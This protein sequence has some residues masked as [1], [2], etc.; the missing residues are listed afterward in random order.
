MTSLVGTTDVDVG[1]ATEVHI[2]DVFKDWD[3]SRR[4]RLSQQRN[5]I[6]TYDD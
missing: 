4:V 1:K 5:R 2:F 3:G 6:V